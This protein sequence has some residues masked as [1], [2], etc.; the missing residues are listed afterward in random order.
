[1]QHIKCRCKHCHKTYYFCTYGNG[2]DYGTEPGCSMEYCGECQTAINKAFSDIPVKFKPKYK[3]IAPSLGL[4]K[5]LDNIKKEQIKKRET[6]AWP[7]VYT[8]GTD[9]GYDNVES[10]THNGKTFRVE[11]NDDTPDDKHY[12]IEMEWDI[13][14]LVYTGNH[15]EANNNNDSYTY[16]QTFR[17]LNRKLTKSLSKFQVGSI[18]YKMPTPSANLYYW[19]VIVPKTKPKPKEHILRT[20]TGTYTGEGIKVLLDHGRALEKVVLGDGLSRDDLI[21]ILDYKTEHQRY[22]DE[23]IE[24]ITKIEVK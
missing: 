14:N 11:W 9:E 13:V 23:N 18:Q 16:Y 19:D 6:Y 10:Y 21:D 15:W 8:S 7:T 3:E 17:K 24:T 20:W 4:E 22:D 2:P 1:M 12:F 5:V